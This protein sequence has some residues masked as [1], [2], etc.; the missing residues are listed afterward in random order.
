MNKDN[1]SLYQLWDE[2][3][4]QWPVEKVRSMSIEQYTLAGSKDTFTYWLE[5]R[6]DKMGSI[7]GGSAFKFGIFSR[8]DSET[9]ESTGKLSYDNNYGWLH[10]YG[11]TR[12]EAFQTI[13][14]E[15]VKIIEAVQSRNI[16]LIEEVDLGYAYKWKIAFHYQDRNEPQ[17][18]SIFKPEALRAITQHQNKKPIAQIHGELIA[19]MNNDQELL[20]YGVSLWSKFSGLATIWKISHGKDSF[21]AKERADFLSRQCVTV[22]KDTKKSQGDAFSE[23][24]NPGDYFYLCHGND[25]G[26]V[27]FGRITSEATV[28]NTEDDWLERSYEVIKKLDEPRRYQGIKKGWAP[29]YNS[30][31]NKVKSNELKLF[32]E[33]ILNKSFG[34]S[35]SDLNASLAGHSQE[36]K[37]GEKLITETM[38]T[39]GLNTIYY[40]PP[41]TGK[42]YKLLT[43]LA[44]ESPKG[45]RRKI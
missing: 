21:S 37:K 8:N 16:G 19:R 42:T 36:G 23:E 5:S 27:L 20:G 18:V 31:V 40:G 26:I 38:N 39:I 32:E 35:L 15:I 3:L 13:R 44:N 12:E 10:K 1:N 22:H 33:H 4:K 45:V 9:K 25:E 41:G 2:F 7:W 29:S 6:L 28:G 43:E 17:I 11:E 30:T 14:A 34:L 24:M